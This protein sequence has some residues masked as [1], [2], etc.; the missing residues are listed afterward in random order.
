MVDDEERTLV[1]AVG[2]G[3]LFMWFP[4][5][6]MMSAAVETQESPYV[7]GRTGADGFVRQ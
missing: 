2:R 7:A 4:R 6:L 5:L 3:C 1:V